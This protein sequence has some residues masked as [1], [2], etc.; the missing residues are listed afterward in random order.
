MAFSLSRQ[1]L[2]FL[3]RFR[4][5]PDSQRDSRLI[6]RLSA[7]FSLPASIQDRK[8]TRNGEISFDNE[9]KRATDGMERE[10]ERVERATS[11]VGRSDSRGA[12][13]REFLLAMNSGS[14]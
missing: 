4:P 14:F 8:A 12:I 5:V 1:V 11:R 10:R 3:F 13:L 9:G 2:R 7:G 6:A